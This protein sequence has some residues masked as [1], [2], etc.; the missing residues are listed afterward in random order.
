[1]DAVLG[2]SSPSALGRRQGGAAAGGSRFRRV[3]ADLSRRCAG[4]A[5]AAPYGPYPW[6]LASPQARQQ[7]AFVTSAGGRIS[8]D[9]HGGEGHRSK[10]A[11][12]CNILS[13]SC[14]LARCVPKPKHHERRMPRRRPLHRRALR[15]TPPAATPT[16]RECADIAL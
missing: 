6:T 13:L 4:V 1:V 16:S 10:A 7:A 11:A 3:Q 9:G 15:A 8:A 12:A 2:K 5:A 14:W